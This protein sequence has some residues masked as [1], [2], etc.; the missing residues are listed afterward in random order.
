MSWSDIIYHNDARRQELTRKIQQF[1]DAMG[2]NFR[3]T[4][5]LATFLNEEAGQNIQMIEVDHAKT[6]K[7]NANLLIAQVQLIQSY[8]E[9][10]DDDLKQE[11]DPDLYRKISDI[12]TSFEV[13]MRDVMDGAHVVASITGAV[14]ST[15]SVRMIARRLVTR[16]V[17]RIARL[18]ASSVAGS[19]IGGI[20]GFAVDIVAG[21]IVGAKEKHE[22]EKALGEVDQELD[23]F[24]P[25]S[26]EYTDTVYEVL[27][28]VRVWK[29][30]HPNTLAVSS[31]AM[32]TLPE[33]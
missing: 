20:A 3:A 21:A 24:L 14:V 15:V 19:I 33:K 1:D 6:V 12:D 25:A 11:L 28:E 8:M 7:E 23:E 9:K 27:A 26:Q 30:H 16:I 32:S 18:A 22:L 29:K 13:T 17:S 10:V 5:K 31:S 4:N 2:E